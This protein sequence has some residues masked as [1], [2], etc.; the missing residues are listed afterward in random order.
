MP[1]DIPILLRA[2]PCHALEDGLVHRLEAAVQRD[3]RHL[4]QHNAPQ[5]SAADLDRNGILDGLIFVCIP[6]HVVRGLKLETSMLVVNRYALSVGRWNLNRREAC[7]ADV[8][9]VGSVLEVAPRLSATLMPAS[10]GLLSTKP[11]SITD[12]VLTAKAVLRRLSQEV[13]RTLRSELSQQQ[14]SCQTHWAQVG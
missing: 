4:V 2:V 8:L 7:V 5:W 3:G 11:R 14:P 12:V 9:G 13:S 1:E 10:D 6:T